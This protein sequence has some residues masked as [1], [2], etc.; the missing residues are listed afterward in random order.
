[1]RRCPGAFCRNPAELLPVAMPA[2]FET[3]PFLNTPCAT[4]MK[5]EA[6][7]CV[8]TCDVNA[9]RHVAIRKKRLHIVAGFFIADLGS[10][11][12]EQLVVRIF[13]VEMAG[14][15]VVGSVAPVMRR[16]VSIIM[17]GL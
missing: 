15:S 1:M 13:G 10:E 12:V 8:T 17:G 3:R 14:R 6:L 5:M 16:I 2:R 4:T 7:R 11:A 9:N